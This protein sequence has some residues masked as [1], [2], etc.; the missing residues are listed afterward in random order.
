MQKIA[1]RVKWNQISRFYL[2][3]YAFQD[4]H[5][6]SVLL[7]MFVS[8]VNLHVQLAALVRIY[9]QVVMGQMDWILAWG[10]LVWTNVPLA[11]I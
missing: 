6:I 7:Q 2:E 4:V 1:N 8:N 3:T 5:Q 10:L 11:S 9:A